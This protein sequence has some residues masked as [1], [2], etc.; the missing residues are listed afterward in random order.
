MRVH[1]NSTHQASL[2]LL[3]GLKTEVINEEFIKALLLKIEQFLTSKGIL[4]LKAYTLYVIRDYM[5]NS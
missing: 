2:A 4:N 5:G 3:M 1:G